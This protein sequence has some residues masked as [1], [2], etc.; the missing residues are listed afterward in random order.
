LLVCSVH[1]HMVLSSL[2]C[3]YWYCFISC[4]W[5]YA[6]WQRLRT[7][8]HSTITAHRKTT[9]STCTQ[10]KEEHTQNKTVTQ[11]FRQKHFPYILL[12]ALHFTSLSFPS[13]PWL[14]LS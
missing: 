3:G 6:R 9:A 2:V 14:S 10:N 5:A 11:N 13:P 4:S 1:L 12:T 7:D 8:V